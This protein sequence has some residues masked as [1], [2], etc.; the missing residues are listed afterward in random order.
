MTD[1]LVRARGEAHGQTPLGGRP[2][3]SWV[4]AALAAAG[5]WLLHHQRTIRGV[6]WC[7]VALY[8]FLVAVPA[9]LPLPPGGAHIWTNLTLFAQFIFWGVWWP[10]V[11]L[12]MV[13]VGRMWCGL[14]CP[15]GFLSETASRHGRGRHTPRWITWKGWPFVA[16]ACTTAYGQ[17]VSVYQYPKPALLILGGSTLAA[18]AVGY[19]FGRGKRVWCR[20][21]CP[22]TGVFGLL[23]KLAPIHFRVDRAAW[24]AAPKPAHAEALLVNC[25]PLVPIRTMKGASQCHMCGRCSG[26]RG[27][28]TLARRSPSHEIVHVAGA[29]PKPWETW[30]IVFGLMGLA[31][32]AFHWASSSLFVTAKQTIAE[33]LIEHGILW[34]L[35]AQ[36]PWWVLTNYPGQNDVMTLL[37]G[38]VLAAY[39]LIAM[40]VIGGM[41]ALCLAASSYILG[42]AGQ[43]ASWRVRFHHLAQSLIPVAGC[44][45]FLGLFGLTATMLHAEGLNLHFLAAVRVALMSAAAVWSALLAWS[46]TRLYAK[47]WSLRCAA[48]APMAVAIAA[49]VAAWAAPF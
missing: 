23:A 47:S 44:G 46:I 24:E 36:A 9:F 15:E 27:A 5:D 25:A 45:V 42:G 11:L 22:V 16:F 31:A 33:R 3:Q 49:G 35:T 26:F 18:I 48:L 17:F 2:A 12:S 13:F 40:A 7:V 20:Y 37:D 1:L 41:V 30:L 6:Q 29:E 28:V 43:S 8:A 32:G 38:A 19:L 4:D 39:L 10:F 21:L 34:P 14:L